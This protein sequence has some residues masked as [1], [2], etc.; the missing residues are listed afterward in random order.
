MDLGMLRWSKEMACAKK[1]YACPSKTA[2]LEAVLLEK[3]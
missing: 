3:F 2:L 1:L